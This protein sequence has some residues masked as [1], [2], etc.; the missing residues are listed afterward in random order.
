MKLSIDEIQDKAFEAHRDLIR[1]GNEC[2]EAQVDYDQLHELSDVVLRN[3][4]PP[5]G[6]VALQELIS[7][8]SLAY[9]DHIKGVMAA[10]RKYLRAKVAYGAQE[11]LCDFLRSAM[12]NKKMLIEKGIDDV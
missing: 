4:L 3:N 1:L 5:T 7:K 8:S 6:A 9:R 2:A 12:S 11:V 10:K